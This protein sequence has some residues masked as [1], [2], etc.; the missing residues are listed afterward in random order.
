MYLNI[1]FCGTAKVRPQ[2]VLHVQITTCRVGIIQ[3]DQVPTALV[4]C[5]LSLRYHIFWF[6]LGPDLT[7]QQRWCWKYK[8]ETEMTGWN[9]VPHGVFL[10]SIQLNLSL[11]PH[12]ATFQTRFLPTEK[13]FS[14]H[15]YKINTIFTQSTAFIILHIITILDGIS[16]RGPS[17][18]ISTSRLGLDHQGA[19]WSLCAFFFCG[20]KKN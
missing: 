1:S 6:I 17:A 9:L 5:L 4:P 14:W 19:T 13:P 7:P 8:N 10:A 16:Q 18:Q 20:V 12:L 15:Q 2:L 3:I 11:S